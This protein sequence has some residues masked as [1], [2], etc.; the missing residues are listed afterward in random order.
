VT[1]PRVALFKKWDRVLDWKVPDAKWFVAGKTNLSYNCLDGQI[2][3]GRGQKVA[4]LWEGEPEAQPGTG[5][6][7]RRITYQQLKD[8]VCRFATA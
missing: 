6:E 3:A 4:I 2:K 1:S 8:D 7:V 5:G